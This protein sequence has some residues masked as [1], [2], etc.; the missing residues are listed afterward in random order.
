MKQKNMK[1]HYVKWGDWFTFTP[2]VPGS[3]DK[4]LVDA[5]WDARK[6]IVDKFPNADCE[7]IRV[8]VEDETYVHMGWRAKASIV[9]YIR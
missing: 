3:S 6:R 2:G 5:V 8:T 9:E 1:V 4:A 7:S